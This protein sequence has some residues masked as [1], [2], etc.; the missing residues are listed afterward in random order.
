MGTAL[1]GGGATG[2]IVAVPLGQLAALGLLAD[3][4]HRGGGA[5]DKGWRC[6]H[7][8]PQGEFRLLFFT[9]LTTFANV[10]TLQVF[11]HHMQGVS[12]F[13]IIFQRLITFSLNVH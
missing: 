9:F 6:S 5:P 10:L 4:R 1:G 12:I 2:H 11:Y 8:I 3:H 7:G 13:T